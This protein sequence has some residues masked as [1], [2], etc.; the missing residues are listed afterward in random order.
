MQDIKRMD[1][2]TQMPNQANEVDRARWQRGRQ[3]GK[4]VSKVA[5]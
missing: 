1:R 4:E 3:G 2:G 5:R